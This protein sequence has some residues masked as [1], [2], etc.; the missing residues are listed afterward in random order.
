MPPTFGKDVQPL[1]AKY[2]YGCHGNGKSVGGVVLDKYKDE[3]S[4]QKKLKIWEKAADNIRSGT[5]PPD[6]R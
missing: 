6:D 1:I 2:C 5:M 4:V 3:E